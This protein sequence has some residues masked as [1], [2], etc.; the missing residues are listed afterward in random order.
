M[1]RL[2]WFHSRPVYPPRG[3]GE[4]RVAGLIECALNLGHEVLLV[5]L[6]GHDSPGESPVPTIAVRD[7]PRMFRLVTKL[8]SRQPLRAGRPTESSL[9]AARAQIDTFRPDLAIVSEIHSAAIAA[10]LAKG[11][12]WIF[13]SYDVS[14]DLY[15]DLARRAPG[16]V[17]RLTYSIDAGRVARLEGE[18]LATCAAVIAVSEADAERIEQL[19]PHAT[20]RVV[21]NSVPLPPVPADPGHAEPVILYVGTL[22][23]PPN[24]RAVEELVHDVLPQVRRSVA[25][26]RLL[27]V[28]RNPTMK[29]RSILEREHWITFRENPADLTESYREARCT[30]LPIR[31]GSGSRIKIYEALAYGVPVI[32]TPLASSGI[33]LIED[34]GCIV[35]EDSGVLAE[36]AI[37]MLKDKAQAQALGAS[38]REYFRKHLSPAQ[39][40]IHPLADLLDQ[41]LTAGRL[42]S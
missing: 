29:L 38:G 5:Q 11:M 18:L 17:S 4:V 12:P 24:V 33:P 31:Q 41:V 40:V 16:A 19:A 7:R 2:L 1:A 13:D 39:S 35:A 27:V 28:G 14:S 15:R 6:D 32:G 22:D 3:G 9:A 26:A 42:D 30:V 25:D 20:V 10:P 37:A 8:F 34:A 21:P 23:Y 36:A